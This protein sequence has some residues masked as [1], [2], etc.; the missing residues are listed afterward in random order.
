[1][2]SLV[3]VPAEEIAIGMWFAYCTC[4]DRGDLEPI[5]TDDDVAKVR[6]DLAEAPGIIWATFRSLDDA[7]QLG[8][9]EWQAAKKELEAMTK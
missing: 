3:T 1:M 2:A 6:A 9:P 8:P 7:M 5:L 4:G